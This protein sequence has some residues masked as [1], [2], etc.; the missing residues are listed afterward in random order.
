MQS[1]A[2]Y[3]FIPEKTVFLSIDSRAPGVA[4]VSNPISCHD[5][6]PSQKVDRSYIRKRRDGKTVQL[7]LGYT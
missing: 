5:F 3:V 1:M 4:Y 2:F 6:G 7:S